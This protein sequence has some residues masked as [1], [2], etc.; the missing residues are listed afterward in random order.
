MGFVPLPLEKIQQPKPKH[1]V[2]V[3]PFPPD[4]VEKQ[5]GIGIIIILLL[6]GLIVGAMF[7]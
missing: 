7:A 6:V 2:E 5:T 3:D 1:P 4:Q